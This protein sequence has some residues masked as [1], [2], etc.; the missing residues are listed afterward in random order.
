MCDA[1]AHPVERLVRTRIG[2]VTSK[3]LNPGELRDLT[4]A[5]LR[6]LMG[7]GPPRRRRGAE[8]RT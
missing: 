4:P 5:E 8:G 7:E 3:G 6:I 1:I 2:P